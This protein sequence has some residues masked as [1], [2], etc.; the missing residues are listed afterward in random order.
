VV[1]DQTPPEV[2]FVEP[3]EGAIYNADSPDRSPATPG[4]QIRVL[5]SADVEDGVVADQLFVDG[6]PAEIAGDPPTFEAGQ[7]TYNAVT[8][9]TGAS[10][11]LEATVCDKANNCAD[12]TPVTI[13][14]DRQAPDVVIAD[15][16]DGFELGA[17]D[18]QSAAAGFQHDVVCD[19]T[20]ASEGDV[21][22]L[23]RN[24]EDEGWETLATHQLAANETNSY[25]FDRATLDP[26][27]DRYAAVQLEVTITD[28]A[29]N[30]SQAY[31]GGTLAPQAPD[32]EITRPEDGRQFNITHD[33]CPED[34]FHWQVDVETIG[35][36]TGDRLVLCICHGAQ[37]PDADPQSADICTR[38]GNGEVVFE[39]TVTG[40]V[41]TL[42]CTPFAEGNNILTAFS[43]NVPGQ[44]N[45]SEPVTVQ[46]DSIPPTVESLAV[47]S[48]ADEDGCVN[49]AEGAMVVTADIS[50]VGTGVEGR[51][52]R[53]IQNWP[54]G[55]AI[56]STTVSGGQA[57]FSTTPADGDFDLTVTVSDQYGSPNIRESNPAIS[58]PEAQFSIRFD[59]TAPTIAITDPEDP[60]L[61]YEDDLDP[62]TE[63]VD[64]DLCAT[65]TGAEDGQL[66]HFLPAAQSESLIGGVACLLTSLGQGPALLE[67]EVTDACGNEATPAS[68]AVF[69]DTIRPTISCSQPSGGDT[70]QDPAVDFICSTSGTD[71]TQRVTVRSGGQQRCQ[72]DVL[73]PGPTTFVC[74]LPAGTH[75]L[76]VTTRD[77][78]GNVSEE[79]Q[80]N[81]VTIEVD[82]CDITLQDLDNPAILNA[83]HDSDGN[84]DNGL[85]LD[86]TACSVTCDSSSCGA[87]E[88]VL[89][90]DGTPVG[91][92]QGLG[93]DGCVTF[94]DVPL[95]DGETGTVI[96]AT[97]DDQ[98]G[99][100]NTS[101]ITVELVDLYAPTL[102]RLAPG[103]DDVVCVA[104][105]GN[106][107]ANGTTILADKVAGEPC[108]IDFSF[109]I[110]DG[111]DPIYPGRLTLELAGNPIGGPTSITSNPQTVDYSNR[112]LDHAT[113]SSLEAVVTD[114]AG[115]EARISLTVEADVVAPAEVADAVPT[116]VDAQHA[117]VDLVWSAVGDDG[118]EGN[119][120]GYLVRWAREAITDS[121]SWQNAEE[122][123]SG[124]GAGASLILP[125]L[126]TYHFSVRAVDEVGNI[127][128]L[129]SGDVVLDNHWNHVEHVRDPGGI[130]G[131]A[132]CNAGDVDGDGIDDLLA[133]APFFDGDVG[134]VMVFQGEAD[135]SNW[136]SP[137]AP[138]VLRRNT[139]GEYFGYFLTRVGDIDSDGFAD[140]AVSGHGFDASRGR[141]S[142]YFGRSDFFSNPPTTSDIEVRGP[143]GTDGLLGR[144]FARLGDIDGD[145][146]TDLF[147]SAYRLD[148]NGRGYI[149]FGRPRAEWTDPSFVNGDDGDGET[150]VPVANADIA[151]LGI[152]VDD[153][154]GYRWGNTSLGDLDGDGYDDFTL[155][156]SAVNEVY[157][158]DGE[159]VQQITGRDVSPASDSVDIL[160]YGETYDMRGFGEYAVG[161]CDITQDG[162]GDLIIS[163][164]NHR[165]IYFFEGIDHGEGD[166]SVTIGLS[167]IRVLT[168]PE[169]INFGE[170]FEV[171]DI[172]MDGLLDMVVGA[173]DSMGQRT[174]IFYNNGD[175]GSPEPYFFD[176]PESTLYGTEGNYFG[177]DMAVGDFNGD[178]L[179]DIAIGEAL[180]ETIHVFFSAN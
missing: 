21:L 95:A 104:A 115:N 7:A 37:C 153:D 177:I 76:R 162:I 22:A 13:L 141:L 88:V 152:E 15:P 16:A 131:F 132:M 180:L 71:A 72:A 154:F 64:F 61:L 92:A 57:V 5:L 78:A 82:G 4:F 175:G 90:L 130:T 17:G 19:F 167:P 53:L 34:G 129:P 160:S 112:Q 157:T 3:L 124:A 75:D 102:T 108:D 29:E 98:Q 85:Q 54:N 27:P 158:F 106:P 159:I 56:A 83:S 139:S 69:V 52:A 79:F 2:A 135:L 122:V 33:M 118:A 77:P 145:G 137:D 70:F 8:A 155:A 42:V 103:A 24:V 176:E 121:A 97:I 148:G 44:G 18:D 10:H 120:Q 40:S 93:A 170:K 31:S 25:T 36:S 110:G 68:M 168:W 30:S 128:P 84:P 47:S 146:I 99:N 173:N 114:Y 96:T 80:I 12:A 66:V 179:P 50:D 20:N 178:Q 1:V 23:R 127:S 81:P 63:D 74:N 43:E 105:S 46:V 11:T 119:P 166:P 116:L 45:F 165:K 174:F 109:E 111:G 142:I 151:F 134:E 91:S 164:P 113:V 60:N 55:S 156:A 89:D 62:G 35:T 59:H 14:V 100:I 48:D 73:I 163:A 41:S 169:H 126:N 125:P 138:V 149:F 39:T 172:N 140:V 9:T 49:F 171:A 133:S 107:D 51:T 123:Y 147:V 38:Y 150:F 144:A 32:V 86:V 143:V 94:R 6:S 101:S 117:D 65:V 161:G 136:S 28:Q 58:D 87:C 67:A 26:T